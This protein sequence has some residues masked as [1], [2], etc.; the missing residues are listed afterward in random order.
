MYTFEGLTI[1]WK[2]ASDATND[3]TSHALSHKKG[4][5]TS[6]HPKEKIIIMLET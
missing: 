2:R 5:E 6:S 1:R 3:P 4:A